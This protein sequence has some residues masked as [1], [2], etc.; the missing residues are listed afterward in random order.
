MCHTDQSVYKL[1]KF[2][3]FVLSICEIVD[4][5]AFSA[6]PSKRLYFPS[7]SLSL[8]FTEKGWNKLLLATHDY[9]FMFFS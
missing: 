4:E 9:Y 3:N 7:K 2:I 8:R 5:V 6:G 1:N